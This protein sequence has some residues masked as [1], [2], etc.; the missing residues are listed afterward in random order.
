MP[1]R[2]GPR[3]PPEGL[4]PLGELVRALPAA[5]GGK[6]PP[7]LWREL[8]A[9]H[10]ARPD[11]L[12]WRRL[13]SGGPAP[14]GCREEAPALALRGLR[15]RDAGIQRAILGLLPALPQRGLKTELR[16]ELRRLAAGCPIDSDTNLALWLAG[17]VLA[18]ETTPADAV[19]RLRE[20]QA[21]A[22]SGWKPGR[23]LD[24]TAPTVASWQT[25]EP[26]Q[27][28]RWLADA[29]ADLV[30][31][32]L[33]SAAQESL[34]D[35][36]LTAWCLRRD[37]RPAGSPP[38]WED[39]RLLLDAAAV[40][41][42]EGDPAK[43][44]RLEALALHLLPARP[45]EPLLQRVRSASWRL[46]EAGLAPP[47]QWRVHLD[48]L[49][50]PGD[51]PT[52]LAGLEA[53]RQWEDAEDP[54]LP[55][56]RAETVEDP[57]WAVLRSSGVVLQHPLAALGWVAKRAQAH[58]V[59]KQHALLEAATRLAL[60][61]QALGSL[62]R[63]LAIRPGSVDNLAAFARLWRASLRA[64]PFLRDI[65]AW[66]E[67]RQHLRLAWG[68]CD[69]EIG[70]S[71][72]RFL[73]HETLQDR[74]TT[75]LRRLPLPWRVTALR[76]VHGRR[77]PSDLVRELEADP[78]RMGLLE[79]QRRVELW[80][81]A[82]ALRERPQLA[83]TVWVSV[84]ASGDPAGGRYSILAAGPLGQQEG[85]GR[86]RTGAEEAASLA[87]VVAAAVQAVADSPEWLVLAV[88]DVWAGV[89]WESELRGAGL[90]SAVAR[91]PGWEWA[92]RVLREDSPAGDPV[93]VLQPEGEAPSG[94]RPEFT[95]SACWL[96]AGT[97]AVDAGTRWRLIGE[98]GPIVRSLGLGASSRIV[99]L[100][101]V[102]T[103]AD[104]S[105]DLVALS[106]AQACRSFLVPMRRLTEVEQEE[107][108]CC[109]AEAGDGLQRLL[110]TGHWRLHGLPAL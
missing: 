109:L 55:L 1:A 40:A 4:R 49:P 43:S 22:P 14:A 99:S 37:A 94:P 48:D 53:A 39:T 18:V 72:T 77:S 96:F 85:G 61:H 12:L 10:G 21:L 101:T 98:K 59:K 73:L 62:G 71:E 34:T 26:T 13:L 35:W 103:G 89:A 6:R 67:G 2:P 52:T 56:V 36:M 93:R 47:A 30:H 38:R 64:M 79:H 82:A 81:I 7:A 65:S 20:L 11:W 87:S 32:A 31:V 78:R 29:V 8:D 19:A 80:E 102:L 24:V 28:R 106:L 45:P 83:G 17:R 15:S 46:A 76:H 97:E 92:F 50:F 44:A 110:A 3:R 105:G 41:R 27:I 66:G 84:V 16:A 88:D 23:P 54:A 90:T 86:L 60:R 33:G 25:A 70:D 104:W 95:P 57:D 69:G 51:P 42:R 68:R 91:V 63:L 58:Q 75:T 108:R 74:L 9:R 107:A 5:S 100:G